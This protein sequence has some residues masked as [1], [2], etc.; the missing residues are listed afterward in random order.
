MRFIIFIILGLSMEPVFS[1]VNMKTKIEVV[2]HRG[3]SLL[4]PEN[5]LAAFKNAL[6]LGVDRIELDVQQT[7]DKVTVV[8]HDSRI[9]RTTTG[10]GTIGK[11]AFA[12]LRT[13]DAGIKFSEQYAGEKVPTLDE[14]LSLV[15]G[16]CTL[17]IEIKNPDNIYS[18]IENDV[19]GLIQK[20]QAHSW[21][22]VQSFSYQS[23]SKVHELDSK[24]KT[25]LLFAKLILKKL[26]NKHADISFIS[27]ISIFHEFANKK[28]IDFI[29]GLNKKVF[30]WTVN[31]PKQMKKMIKNGVDGIISDDPK[32]LME[33]VGK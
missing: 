14:V 2:A 31:T 25:V 17:L 28:T 22:V 7:K 23:V 6:R 21:C 5:T 20:H 4:A 12:Q 11:L 9:N 19:V 32:T 13:Y 3:G 30:V 18:G 33:L 8:I 10:K 15:N 24:I 29:H 16:Q 1:Q 27:E 26:S